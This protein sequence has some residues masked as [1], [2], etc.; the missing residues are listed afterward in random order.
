[1]SIRLRFENAGGQNAASD[2]DALQKTTAGEGGV[3]FLAFLG[4]LLDTH[5]SPSFGRSVIDLSKRL[6]VLVVRLP[7]LEVMCPGVVVRKRPCC[8]LSHAAGGKVLE[9]VATDLHDGFPDLR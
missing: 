7:G 2:A 9:H 3:A 4:V 6:S 5:R 8:P 1:M